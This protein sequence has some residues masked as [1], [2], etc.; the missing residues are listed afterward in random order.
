MLLRAYVG[1]WNRSDVGRL[2]HTGRIG[3]QDLG[4]PLVELESATSDGI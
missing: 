3:F 1:I 2:R 4:S